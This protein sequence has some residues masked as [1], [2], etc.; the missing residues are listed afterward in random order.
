LG[1]RI[2]S[3]INVQR[4]ATKKNK[5]FA[6]KHINPMNFCFFENTTDSVRAKTSHDKEKL[7]SAIVTV[8]NLEDFISAYPE[9][10]LAFE[11]EDHRLKQRKSKNFIP[12]DLMKSHNLRQMSYTT[13]EVNL[14]RK[15]PGTKKFTHRYTQTLI[16]I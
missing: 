16:M 6:K 8:K 12:V 10:Y 14:R 5:F 11:T 13:S 2:K 3:A 9:D 4:S 15:E 7:K 1:R